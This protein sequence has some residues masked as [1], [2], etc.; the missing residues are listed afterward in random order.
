MSADSSERALV[1][2][3]VGLGSN[4][5]DRFATL[6][7]AVEAIDRIP[8]TRVVRTSAWLEN[9][10]VGI[11]GGPDFL[12]GVAEI[13]TGL[14]AETLLDHLLAIELAHGRF[15]TPTEGYQSRTL[16]LDIL[17]FGNQQLSTDRITVPH[18]RLLEREFV[19]AP[20]RELG[21]EL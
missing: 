17:L 20:L 5:G 21:V 15:R 13:E 6:E 4:L 14:D 19:L 12:N 16:D 2:A 8:H 9:P 10:A 18:P 7:S 1:K 3:Y 11:E